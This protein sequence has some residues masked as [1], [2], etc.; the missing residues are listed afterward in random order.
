MKTFTYNENQDKHI[1]TERDPIS[2]ATV[3][4]RYGL[5]LLPFEDKP[6]YSDDA[7]N[8]REQYQYLERNLVKFPKGYSDTFNNDVQGIL[9]GE[10]LIHER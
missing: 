2:G 4:V 7:D 6:I 8:R 5:I 10:K 3:A 9:F 1:V